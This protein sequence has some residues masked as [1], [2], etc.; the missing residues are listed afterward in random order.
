MLTLEEIQAALQ[1]L[2]PEV[3]AADT[4]LAASTVYKYRAGKITDPPH[5][6]MRVLSE[7]L[8]PKEAA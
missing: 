7:Y 2:R 5:E 6:T 3:V 1:D 8:A 4:G